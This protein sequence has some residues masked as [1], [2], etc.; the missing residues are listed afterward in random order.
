[1]DVSYMQR[2]APIL[3]KSAGMTMSLAVISL[4][5][6]LILAIVIALI[7]YYKIPVLVNFSKLY[8]S[9][10]R[11][12]PALIQLYLIYFGLGNAGI[13]FFRNMSAFTAVIIALSLNMSAYMAENLRGALYSVDGG[14]IEAGI[15]IGLSNLQIFRHIVFPQAFRVAVPSLGNSFVDLIKGSS[16]AF[17]IGVI[18]L[19]ASANLQGVASYKFLEAFSVAAIIY[20]ILTMVVNYLQKKLEAYLNRAY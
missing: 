11:G 16:M 5:I 14:Q 4:V 9:F 13:E 7:I 20:W 8:V 19:M 2:I 1:M 12:T 6:S 18:E 10:F 15:T 17:T 3:V